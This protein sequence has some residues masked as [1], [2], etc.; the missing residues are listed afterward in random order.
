MFALQY[1][2]LESATRTLSATEQ[3]SREMRRSAFA[4]ECSGDR[5]EQLVLALVFCLESSSN[6]NLLSMHTRCS[7]RRSLLVTSRRQWRHVSLV[8][9]LASTS[10]LA[11]DLSLASESRRTRRAEI[12]TDAD[13]TGV[14]RHSGRRCVALL[15][16]LR[17]RTA[18]LR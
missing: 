2:H 8:C 4:R 3:C 13:S 11:I 14:L 7:C 10:L 6:C 18:S 12:I 17:R 1:F 16:V 9:D 15:C 5:T